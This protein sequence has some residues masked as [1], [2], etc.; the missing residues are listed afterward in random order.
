LPPRFS[1]FWLPQCVTR[2]IIN[3]ASYGGNKSAFSSWG[4][5]NMIGN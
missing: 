4:K 1:P 5:V 3:L 2:N